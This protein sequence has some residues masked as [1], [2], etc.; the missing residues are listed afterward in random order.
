MGVYKSLVFP[1][2]KAFIS[3]LSLFPFIPDCELV[4]SLLSLSV[5]CCTL[6]N[7]ANDQEWNQDVDSFQKTFS[8]ALRSKKWSY[9]EEEDIFNTYKKL[10]QSHTNIPAN[11]K[12][13]HKIQE[14]SGKIWTGILQKRK[15]K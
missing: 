14:N 7:S 12:E 6:L 3:V 13:K 15:H 4:V 10:T 1:T 9:K 2:W 5:S 11:H 8:R